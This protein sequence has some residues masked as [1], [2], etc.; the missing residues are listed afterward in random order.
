MPTMTHWQEVQSYSVAHDCEMAR[1][2]GFDD[3]TREHWMMIETGA[4]FRER[5]QEAVQRIMDAI[6]DGHEP[7]EVEQQ[8]N[9]R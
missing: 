6:E 7:G 5:R 8:E 2:S 1:I 9:E 3:H 4:G